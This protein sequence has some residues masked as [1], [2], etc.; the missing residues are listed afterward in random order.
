MTCLTEGQLNDYATGRLSTRERWELGRHL[1]AC[2]DCQAQVEQLRQAGAWLDLLGEAEVTNHHVKPEVLALLAEGSLDA[3]SRAQ[4]LAHVGHCPECATVLGTLVRGLAQE[5]DIQ[6]AAARASAPLAAE[7][8][9]RRFVPWTAF[10]AAAAAFAVVGA[11]LLTQFGDRSAVVPVPAMSAEQAMRSAAPSTG[12]ATPE[13]PTE[14]APQTVSPAADKL[15][16]GPSATHKAPMP[17]GEART[18]PRGTSR[19]PDAAR[20]RADSRGGSLDGRAMAKTPVAPVRAAPH[21]A[22]QGPPGPGDRPAAIGL[23]GGRGGGPGAAKASGMPEAP[24][25]MGSTRGPAPAGLGGATGGSGR[26]GMPGPQST[27]AL[28]ATDGTE[29][30]AVASRATGAPVAAA[31]FTNNQIMR[32]LPAANQALVQR[33]EST[34]EKAHPAEAARDAAETEAPVSQQA[35]L[36]AQPLRNKKTQVKPEEP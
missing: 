15:A 19:G 23:R 24:G 17:S 26:A 6:V 33:R 27:T 32:R 5:A 28:G 9:R 34:P 16:Q 22:L 10:A 29:A 13:R 18:G 35:S 14:T 31:A 30:L 25:I 20:P 36:R 12:A 7:G 21:A 3:A 11:I 2:P 1:E 8:R 4:A